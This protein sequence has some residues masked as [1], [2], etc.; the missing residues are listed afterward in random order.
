MM[1]VVAFVA[2]ILGGVSEGIRIS[3]LAKY[4]RG[5]AEY[6][7]SHARSIATSIYDDQGRALASTEEL[8]RLDPIWEAH[9]IALKRKYERAAAMPWV[10]VPRDPPDPLNALARVRSRRPGFSISFRPR[11]V[12]FK[13]ARG[14]K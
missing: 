6:H 8:G 5:R 13:T 3:S 4:Y 7:A 10:L 11:N 2:L 12:G 14:G 1:A 9:H